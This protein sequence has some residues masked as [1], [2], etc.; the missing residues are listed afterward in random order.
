MMFLYRL[1]YDIY[2]FVFFM[3][4]NYLKTTETINNN[5]Y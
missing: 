3:S 5:K 1:K 4:G 2:I